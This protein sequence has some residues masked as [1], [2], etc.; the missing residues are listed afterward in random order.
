MKIS[1]V[2]TL[3]S[4]VLGATLL[5]AESLQAAPTTTIV[6]DST[7]DTMSDDGVCTLREAI[8]AANTNSAVG[9]CAAGDDSGLGDA[10]EFAIPGDGPHTIKLQ[11]ELPAVTSRVNIDGLSQPGAT[12]ASNIP[13]AQLAGAATAMTE[14]MVELDGSEAGSASGLVFEDGSEFAAVRGL[15]INQFEKDGI[16]IGVS[17]DFFGVNAFCN[18]IGIDADGATVAANKM[19]GISIQ[20]SAG[21]S[22]QS[23]VLSGNQGRGILISEPDAKDNRVE[24]NYI[25]TNENGANLGNAMDGVLG[26]NSGPQVIGGTYTGEGCCVGNTIAFNG[27]SGVAVSA[28]LNVSLEKGIRGNR[29]YSNDGLGIDLE[30][31]GV[32]LNDAGDDDGENSAN[33]LQNFPVI[34]S[35]S[36]I[37]GSAY[38]TGTL[39]SK[40]EQ[41]YQIDFF[42]NDECDP[43]GYGEGQ[44]FIGVESVTTNDAGNISFTA[45]FTDTAVELVSGGD[46]I[47]AT[48]SDPSGNTS[49][50]GE[51][52]EIIS[53]DEKDIRVLLPLMLG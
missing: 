52:E 11:S 43:S 33:G 21:N 29:I 9:G 53:L 32:T 2:L 10:I 36:I 31:D 8:Q 1:I 4:V 49:E 23:N 28:A 14:L 37:S 19:N 25:G 41:R 18:W 50:F 39:N 34:E 6:V 26:I 24:D 47:T 44:R 51:C 7:L 12:C 42:A 22:L 38:I 35:A 15:I 27:G 17:T 45:V 13:A 16:F 20:D 46:L 5:L 40:A 30:M 3:C 48:A